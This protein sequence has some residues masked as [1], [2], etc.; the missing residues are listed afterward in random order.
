MS[1]NALHPSPDDLDVSIMDLSPLAWVL[2]E[3]RKSLDNASKALRRFVRE[4]AQA[5]GAELA[6]LDASQ[7]RLARQQ[8]HQAA[9]A[10][11]MVGMGAPA[12]VLRAMETVVQ[13]FMQ[14]PEQCTEQASSKVELAGFALTAYL[15]DVLAGKPVSAV[16]LF[17]QYRDIQGLIGADRIHPADLWVFEWR[18]LEPELPATAPP[19]SYS[20]ASRQQ[21][22]R[23]TLRLVRSG[24]RQAARGLSD[25]C[26]GLSHMDTALE[27]RTFWKIA[28]GFFEG[29]ALGLLT[30]DVY[31]KRAILR[32][33]TPIIRQ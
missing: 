6:A 9:G 19:T 20:D 23:L 17:P 26:L 11:D 8:L 28:A 31:A 10:L 32:C 12:L 14:S 25:I 22:D 15:E 29:L 4:A 16:S 30:V 27:L 33:C 5:Q 13:R 18:W 3:L 24:D 1:S 21:L 2:E 7:L